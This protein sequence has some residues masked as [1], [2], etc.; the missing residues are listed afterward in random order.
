MQGRDTPTTPGKKQKTTTTNKQKALQ[1][2]VGC[3][4]NVTLSG[5]FLQI[6]QPCQDGRFPFSTKSIQ[7]R[8]NFSL[9]KPLGKVN[10]ARCNT[11]ARA[12]A[13]RTQML[14]A[15]TACRREHRHATHRLARTQMR[16]EQTVHAEQRTQRLQHQKAPETL[17]ASRK[18]PPQT[19]YDQQLLITN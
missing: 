18:L 4:L 1:A 14:A 2:S 17:R 10:F 7:K 5:R 19:D 8:K 11:A 13:L 6:R 15:Q 3:E 12:N 16:P 9:F